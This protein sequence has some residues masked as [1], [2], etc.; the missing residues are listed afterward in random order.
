MGHKDQKSEFKT[1]NGFV[2]F[3]QNLNEHILNF[4]TTHV[5]VLF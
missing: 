4:D 5:Y 1:S 2:S 3:F